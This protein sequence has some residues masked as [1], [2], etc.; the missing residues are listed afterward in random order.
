MFWY[1][2]D[3]HHYVAPI[4]PGG[5]R[6]RSGGPVRKKRTRVLDD[7]ELRLV[8]QA[9]DDIGKPRKDGKSAELRANYGKMVKLLLLTT[10]RLTMLLDM[11][12]SDLRDGVK[13]PTK[14]R[15]A[16]PELVDNVWVMRASANE[17]A[18]GIGGALRLPPL[19]LEIL[20]SIPKVDGVEYVFHARAKGNPVNKPFNS[21]SQLKAELDAL[22]P[23]DMRGDGKAEWNLH[24]LRR[25]ARTLMPQAGVSEYVAE[26]VLGHKVQ[27]IESVY[28]LYDY[29]HDKADALLRLSDLVSRIIDPPD[30]TNVVPYRPRSA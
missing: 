2:E 9:C 22:L 17:L 14:D 25:T 6:R 12:W 20:S 8:W 18:K 21:K 10:Q 15:S 26:R 5:K 7:D 19:A 4:K 30:A 1:A 23:K 16:P 13:L 29:F 11:K 3:H 28:N 24:D 27:G